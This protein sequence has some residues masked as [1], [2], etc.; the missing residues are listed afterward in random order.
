MTSLL[1]HW[2]FDP[3]MLVIVLVITVHARG[4]RLRL[5][6]ISH[7][8]RPTRAWSGQAALFY[9]GIAAVTVAIASPL[10]YWA[11]IYLTAHIVQ[12]ILLSFVAAPL[13][14]LGAPWLP[15]LRGLPGPLR[16]GLGRLAQRTQTSVRLERNQAQGRRAR[17]GWLRSLVGFG[18]CSH[19]PQ[20]PCCCST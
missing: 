13:V 5:R 10:D 9:L 2:S 19:G 20:P 16:R 17:R 15:L 3:A 18:T 4:L 8:G 7:A 11:D 14:V 1:R 6:A 12:H